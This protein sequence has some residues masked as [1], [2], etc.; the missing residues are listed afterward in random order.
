MEYKAILDAQGVLNKRE[1]DLQAQV[2][3]LSKDEYRLY[4]EGAK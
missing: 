1:S 2:K 4:F 3:G